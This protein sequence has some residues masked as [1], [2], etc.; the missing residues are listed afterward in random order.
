M[1][2]QKLPNASAVL[3]LGILSI[4]TCW[5]YGIIGVI[6]GVI[7]LLLASKDLKT[8]RISPEKFDN[9]QNLNIGKILAIIGLVLSVLT[10][11]FLIWIFSIIGFDNLEDQEATRQKLMD[12][13]NK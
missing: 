8:Y 3:I 4:L 7:A 12:Y 10:I 5:C 11:L 13:F 1:E 6:L 2:N 9:Y